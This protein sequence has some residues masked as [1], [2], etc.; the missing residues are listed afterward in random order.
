[1]ETARRAQIMAATIAEAGFAGASFAHIAG[2]L[3]IGR[4]LISYHFAGW[5]TS[6]RP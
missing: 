5:M 1:M 4:G 2:K 6:S 3:G